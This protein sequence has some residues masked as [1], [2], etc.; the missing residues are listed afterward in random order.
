MYK[1]IQK[2][3]FRCVPNKQQKKVVSTVAGFA[4]ADWTT[5]TRA[6]IRVYEDLSLL[7]I[8]R[9]KSG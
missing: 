2:W 4:A 3:V 5:T 9:A 8:K 6:H 7:L 1:C